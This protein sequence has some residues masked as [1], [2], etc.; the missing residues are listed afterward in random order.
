MV[1]VG[2]GF[3]NVTLRVK[4]QKR[5]RSRGGEEFLYATPQSEHRASAMNITN[6]YCLHETFHSHFRRDQDSAESI[7][8][9]VLPFRNG[10]LVFHIPV[11]QDFW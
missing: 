6:Y 8:V 2:D 7:A 9:D 4:V 5:D 1:N 10:S 3:D 11:L